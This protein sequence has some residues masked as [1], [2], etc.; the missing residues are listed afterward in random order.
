MWY[1][2]VYPVSPGVVAPSMHARLAPTTVCSL[3][4]SY[5]LHAIELFSYISLLLLLAKHCCSSLAMWWV[6]GCVSL[7]L[8][9]KKNQRSG[10]W[11]CGVYPVSPGV[12]ALSMHASLAPTTVCSL[13]T[14]YSFLLS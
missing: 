10:M 11:Y 12:V 8:G 5:S 13:F 4:T 6:L 14:M 3:F 9:P 1:C 2:G 7:Y